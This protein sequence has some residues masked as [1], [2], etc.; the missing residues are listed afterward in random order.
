MVDFAVYLL[1]MV[2]IWGILSLSLNLQYGTTGLLNLGQVVFFML[3][4]YLSTILVVLAG[5]PIG[6]GMLGGIA[7]AALFGVLMALPTANLQQDYW[8]KNLIRMVHQYYAT[9][10]PMQYH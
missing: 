10:V 9:P 7:V 4:A 1:T 5:L 6:V 2:G 8:R 3:G